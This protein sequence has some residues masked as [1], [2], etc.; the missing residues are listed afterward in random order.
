MKEVEAANSKYTSEK[1]NRNNMEIQKNRLDKQNRDLED[2]VSKLDTTLKTKVRSS[3]YTC[4]KSAAFYI[5]TYISCC[6]IR[7]FTHGAK[8]LNR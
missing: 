8:D 1:E 6:D 2:Q 7:L 3:L 4:L 5:Y